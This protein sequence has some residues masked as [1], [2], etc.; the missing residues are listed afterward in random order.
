MDQDGSL[1][2]ADQLA[3]QGWAA[4]AQF[5]SPDLVD[6]LA[7]EARAMRA[8]GRFRAAA[9]GSGARRRVDAEVRGDET[10]WLDPASA[11]PAQREY[12]EALDALR[13]ALNRELQLGLF[14]FETHFAFYPRGA[15]YHRHR[16]RP[17]GSEARIVSSVLYLNETW[18]PED[19]GELRLYIDESGKGAYRQFLPDAGSLVCFLSER[20]WHEVLPAR[21]ERW[22]VSGWFVRR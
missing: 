2:I 16:D 15:R 10:C 20:F 22:S 9:V 19:G 8:A 13:A 6:A 14:D 5:I 11:T 12:L 17:H 3:S 1:Q 7:D 18:K 4:V 21:R